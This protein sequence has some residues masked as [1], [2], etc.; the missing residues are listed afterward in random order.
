MSKNNTIKMALVAVVSASGAVSMTAQAQDATVGTIAEVLGN[1]SV[2]SNP[3][4]FG[5]FTPGQNAGYISIGA[6]QSVSGLSG[7]TLIGGASAGELYL[8]GTPGQNVSV[9]I[10]GVSSLVGPGAPMVLNQVGLSN[11]STSLGSNSVI[12]LSPNGASTV[13]L[14][15][16]L[17]VPGNQTPGVYFGTVNVVVSYV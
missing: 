5:K 15:G 7:V 4:N 8:Y 6:D 2:N 13:K 10:A 3:I 17:E 14:F 1:L 16:Q 11:G 12:S 9:S